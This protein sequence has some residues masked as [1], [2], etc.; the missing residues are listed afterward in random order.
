MNGFKKHIMETRKNLVSLN[1]IEERYRTVKPKYK[2]HMRASRLGSD[3]QKG[4]NEAIEFFYHSLVNEAKLLFATLPNK[5]D[6]VMVIL[7]LKHDP[8]NLSGIHAIITSTL[9]VQLECDYYNNYRIEYQFYRCPFEKRIQELIN[10][11][12]LRSFSTQITT[13]PDY[14]AFFRRVLA[15]QPENFIHLL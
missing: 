6:K 8:V 5:E 13:Q 4:M 10:R 2:N 11:L 3:K 9:Y 7:D 12:T 14:P 15:C 1:E